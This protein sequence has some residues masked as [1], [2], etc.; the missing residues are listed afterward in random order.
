MRGG[1]ASRGSQVRC[2]WLL[3]PGVWEIRD[4]ASP[5]QPCRVLGSLGAQAAGSASPGLGSMQEAGALGC[6]LGGVT[7]LPR[8]PPG[9]PP[10]SPS[11]SCCWGLRGQLQAGQ[12]HP[13]PRLQ[14]R[15]GTAWAIS[16]RHSGKGS[17]VGPRAQLEAPGGR[18]TTRGW[19]GQLLQAK[20]MGRPGA[21]WLCI[22]RG[23]VHAPSCLTGPGP[24]TPTRHFPQTSC[25]HP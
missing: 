19:G 6:R 23:V 10:R 17:A 9:C 15:D 4:E 24:D 20:S 12:Q 3:L 22:P 5:G 2:T 18:Q 14:R 25:C 16:A 1:G 21:S 8:W 11:S 13:L 7:G